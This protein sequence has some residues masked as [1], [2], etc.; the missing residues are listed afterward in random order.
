MSLGYFIFIYWL[1]AAIIL[2]LGMIGYHVKVLGALGKYGY[3]DTIKL[4]PSNQIKQI[5]QYEQICREEGVQTGWE[6]FM[7]WFPTI[8][9]LLVIGW[10][11]LLAIDFIYT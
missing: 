3:D 11:A 10:F 8:G 2:V 1:L 4:L 6:K 5:K 7:V 9:F